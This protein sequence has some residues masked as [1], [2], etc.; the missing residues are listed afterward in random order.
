MEEESSEVVGEREE[1]DEVEEQLAKEVETVRLEEVVLLDLIDELDVLS[2]ARVDLSLS[3]LTVVK[4]P[5]SG[6]SELVLLLVH[7]KSI[8]DS[9]LLLHCSGPTQIVVVEEVVQGTVAA[10]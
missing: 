8:T 4:T 6:V 1:E 2:I 7:S 3:T 5:S 10:D 9:L